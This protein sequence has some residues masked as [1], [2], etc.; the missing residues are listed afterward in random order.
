MRDMC[1]HLCAQL[2]AFFKAFGFNRPFSL[3]FSKIISFNLTLNEQEIS[4]LR[5]L[6]IYFNLP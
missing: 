3:F 4:E 2:V 1:A 6:C 5:K